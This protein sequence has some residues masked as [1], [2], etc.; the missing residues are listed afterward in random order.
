MTKGTDTR[1]AILDIAL[2]KASQ[3]GLGALSIGELA[4]EAGMS[5]SGLFAHFE[6]KENLQLEVMKAAAQ[7]FVERIVTPAL[8]VPRGEPRVRALFEGWF[9]WAKDSKLPGGCLFIAAATELDDQPGPLRDYLV[10]SQRDWLAAFAQAAKIAVD[11]KHFRNDL[12]TEKFARR[13][14]SIILAY[15][16]F[17]RLLHMTDAEAQARSEFDALLAESRA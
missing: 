8:R 17:S 10:G 1:D 9:R 2:A 4:K 3:V 11:E 13:V 12:D 5:K 14:Y 15:H 16:H 6:S 7:R